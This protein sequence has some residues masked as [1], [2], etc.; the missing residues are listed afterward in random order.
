MIRDQSHETNPRC[1]CG[2]VG[3]ARSRCSSVRAGFTSRD[4]DLA[5]GCRSASVPNRHSISRPNSRLTFR[6]WPTRSEKEI[7]NG[8]NSLNKP[9]RSLNQSSKS[10]TTSRRVRRFKSKDSTA[11]TSRLKSKGRSTLKKSLSSALIMTVLEARREQ[12]TT[13]AELL[14]C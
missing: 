7:W 8:T 5:I 14:P 9:P 6:I 1:R 13:A 4:V 3:F 10:T 12:T 2:A 11:T